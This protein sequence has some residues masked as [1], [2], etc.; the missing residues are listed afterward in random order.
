MIPGWG[1]LRNVGVPMYGALALWLTGLCTLWSERPPQAV[2]QHELPD[3]SGARLREPEGA[4]G[5]RHDAG[6]GAR[7]GAV[8][9]VMFPSGVILPMY[10]TNGSEK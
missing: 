2:P 3:L 8:K 1:I 5:A 6:Q 4:I 7:V 9:R 10:P